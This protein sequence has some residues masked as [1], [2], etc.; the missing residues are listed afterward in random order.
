MKKLLLIPSALLLTLF[1][2]LTSQ[3]AIAGSATWSNTPS[4][5][6]WNDAANWDPN[7]IPNGT[8][9]VATFSASNIAGVA[10]T[11]ANI[12]LDSVVFDSGAPPYTISVQKYE[13]D[14]GGAGIVN[15]SGATQSF[16]VSNDAYVSFSDGASAGEGT[17]FFD[18][19]GGIAFID[20]ASAGSGTFNVTS[21]GMVGFNTYMDFNNGATAANATINLS[22]GAYIIFF[23]SNGGNATFNVS[24]G[25]YLQ[26]GGGSVDH[27]IVNCIGGGGDLFGS[28]WILLVGDVSAGDGVFTA[29]GGSTSGEQGGMIY[30]ADRGTADNA[31]FVVGGG[32]GAGLAATTLTFEDS[33]T[34]ANS[35]I[36]A[37]GGVGGSEGGT[38]YF[39]NRSKGGTASISLLGNGTLDISGHTTGGVTIGSLSG[40]GLVFLGANGLTIGSNNQSTTFSGT[41]QDGGVSGGSG[42]SLMKLG[43]GTLTLSGAS[44]YTGRTTVSAG[45][46]VVSNR[47]GSATGTGTVQVNA[48]TLGGSG[49]I[50]GAVT[51][52]SGSFL[53]PAHGTKTQSILTIQSA[54]TFNS[55]STYTYTFKAKGKQAKTDKVIANGVTI[56]SG[57]NVTI[58]VRPKGV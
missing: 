41:M 53:S 13:L 24:A 18:M 58:R 34:A 45:T 31:T 42:G 54:L 55:G 26:F 40:D 33:T 7:T 37:N 28:S 2:I 47:N 48:G 15:T 22:G 43:S 16:V 1:L 39:E 35:N 57:A 6:D 29:V 56:N 12:A 52:N 50:S 5:G 49:I 14:I 10:I 4:S 27:A 8:S 17:S 11:N 21:G 36:T 23:E 44:A 19:G 9:D 3:S 25:S 20:S 38:I 46:L 30:L 32:L 51:L